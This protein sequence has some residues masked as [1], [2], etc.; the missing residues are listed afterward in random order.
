MRASSHVEYI[1]LRYVPNIL[2]TEDVAIATI[3]ISS[4]DQH[5]MICDRGWQS[6]VRILDTNADV[7]MLSNLLEEI[8][9]RL[10]SPSESSEM[11]Q[12]LEDS[13]SNILQVSARRRG[14]LD[15]FS[16]SLEDGAC[17]RMPPEFGVADYRDRRSTISRENDCIPLIK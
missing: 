9:C 15:L 1:I 10:L 16:E 7:D 14:P 2:G 12:Q 4:G 11:I 8:R 17:E 3:L 6:K 13:F 5:D